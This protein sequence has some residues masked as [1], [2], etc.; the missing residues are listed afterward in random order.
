MPLQGRDAPD[1]A[2]F[3]A[4]ERPDSR[5]P[6]RDV[7]AERMVLGARVMA[8]FRVQLPCGKSEVKGCHS[9]GFAPTSPPGKFKILDGIAGRSK[10]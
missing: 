10:A 9:S 3:E 4:G 2:R 7:T 5:V 1:A 8:A 6:V